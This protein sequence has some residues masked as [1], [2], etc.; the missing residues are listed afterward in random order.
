MLGDGQIDKPGKRVCALWSRRLGKD[1]CMLNILATIAVQKP[2][3]YYYMGPTMSQVK[4]FVWNN[5]GSDGRMVID[6]AFPVST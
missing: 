3:L 5:I 1:S 6:Q 2:G 4:K